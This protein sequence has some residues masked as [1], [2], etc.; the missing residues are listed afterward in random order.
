MLK[1]Y[2]FIVYPQD[3]YGV[4]NI[5]VTAYTLTEAR[6]IINNTFAKLNWMQISEVEI[7]NAEVIENIN[8][9]LLD[10]NHVI[11]NM[12]VVTFKGVWFP[13]LNL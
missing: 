11:P 6:Q 4:R 13:R 2:W 7:E 1:R 5:G 8:I 12:G 10:T 9:E 3:K